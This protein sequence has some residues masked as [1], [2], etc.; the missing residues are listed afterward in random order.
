MLDSDAHELY[1]FPSHVRLDEDLSIME[2]LTPTTDFEDTSDAISED[3][4]EDGIASRWW[5]AEAQNA[6]ETTTS[7][8]DIQ[9]ICKYVPFSNPKTGIL[10]LSKQWKPR[11]DTLLISAHV[12]SDTPWS[13]QV[14]M[15]EW[16][17]SHV[18]ESIVGLLMKGQRIS[19]V[20]RRRRCWTPPSPNSPVSAEEIA[21]S[22]DNHFCFLFQ[23]V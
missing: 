7:V 21:E 14:K 5:E 18:A 4:D 3:Q 1:W 11:L 15:H 17:P 12:K 22:L 9:L 13:P 10:A 8:K 6:L 2:P 20:P 16:S 23:H 19:T